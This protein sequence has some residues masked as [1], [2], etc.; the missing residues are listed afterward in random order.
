MEKDEDRHRERE[1][2]R[3]RRSPIDRVFASELNCVCVTVC[4]YSLSFSIYPSPH[5][6]LSSPPRP[7]TVG[8]A[9]ELF[10][11]NLEPPQQRISDQT[12]RR[13]PPD[14]AVQDRSYPGNCIGQ[15]TS[16]VRSN[17]YVTFERGSSCLS[18]GRLLPAEPRSAREQLE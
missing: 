1:D 7:L 2:E 13:R 3:L 16:F 4:V 11:Q 18:S 10:R 14:R 5:L 15:R 9:V 8:L 6:L 12:T 17:F